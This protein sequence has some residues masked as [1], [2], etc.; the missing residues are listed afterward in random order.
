MTLDGWI[1]KYNSKTPEEF[2]RDE[3]FE[4]FYLPNKGFC[5]VGQSG[6]MIIINQLC[7]DARY[8]NAKVSEMARKVGAKMCGTWCIRDGIRAYIRLFG[9][10]VK[11]VD[12]LKDGLCRYHCVNADGKR[13]EVSPAFTYRKGG[14]HAYFITWEP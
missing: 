1:A 14:T 13:G 7:G 12:K 6:D 11:S 2:E 5:E 4:L 8:W 9:Y 10:R 3:R